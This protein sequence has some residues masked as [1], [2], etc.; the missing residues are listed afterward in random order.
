M[1]LHNAGKHRAGCLEL[2]ACV[3]LIVVAVI[4]ALA[5]S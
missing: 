4:L 5:L 3:A 2:L 1:E